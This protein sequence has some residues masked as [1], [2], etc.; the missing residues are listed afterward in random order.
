MNGKKCCNA[1]AVVTACIGSLILAA[2]LQAAAPPRPPELEAGSG[3]VELIVLLAAGSSASSPF[4]P[5]GLVAE[6]NGGH[7]SLPLPA[8]P[9]EARPL[10]HFR[11]SGPRLAQL[12]A[13]PDSPRARLERYVVLRF[14]PGTDVEAV[15]AALAADPRILHAEEN[16]VFHLSTTTPNDPLYQPFPSGCK[17]NNPPNCDPTKYQWGSYS[18]SLGSAWDRVK[19][20]AYVGLLDTGMQVAHPDLR[21]FHQD[22]TGAWIFDGGPYRPQFSYDFWYLSPDIDEA[23]V[24]AGLTPTNFGHGTHV[25]GILAATPNNSQ[26]VAGAC[27]YCS[28]MMARVSQI[29]AAAGG[30]LYND[31]PTLGSIAAGLTWLVDHGAQ[32]VS[33]S[34]GGPAPTCANAPA[35]QAVLCN[36]LAYADAHDVSFLAASGN[37]GSGQIDFPAADSRSIA[38]GGIMENGT[39]WT[40][41][42]SSQSCASAGLC[43]SNYGPGQTLVAPARIV[44]STFYQGHTYFPPFCGDTSGYGLCTG[45]SMASPYAAGVAALVRS[46]N[47]L[48]KKGDV[49]NILTTTASHP[50]SPDSQLGYGIPNAAAAVSAA[51]GIAGGRAIA[52]RLTPLFS[53]YSSTAT[54]SFYT[55]VPQMAASAVLDPET[56]YVSTGPAVP[57]YSGFPG[58]PG[59]TVSPCTSGPSA[60]VYIFTTDTAPYSG[61]PPLVP[62]YRL[63]YRGTFNGNVHHRDTTY[64]TSTVGVTS[65]KGVGYNFDGIEGYVYS[66]CTPEPQCI[67]NGAVRLYR[68]YNPNRDDW[69]IFP[70][71]ELAQKQADGYQHAACCNDVIGYVY[72]N[73][74]TDGDGLIDGFE[75][76]IGTNPRVADSDCDGISDGVEVLNYPYSDPLGPGCGGPPVAN[77]TFSCTGLT[78]SFDASSTSSAAGITAYSW[79]F[80]D[81]TS[82]SGVTTSHTYANYTNY[83]VNLTVTDKIL[84]QSSVQ[85]TVSVTSQLPDCSTY[86]T[87][88]RGCYVNECQVLGHPQSCGDWGICQFSCYC[89][90]DC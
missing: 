45:T 28:I 83:N 22:G 26:G 68:L 53:F 67:P 90:G 88:A 29:R 60:S 40:E 62:L 87:C 5:E 64:T 15:K 66:T 24:K 38:V 73:V 36:A 16:V 63:S 75:L 34:L 70:E 18:L 65:F 43:G 27:W 37:A 59:C 72:P 74:D 71:S 1:S 79:N 80:G 55:T 76:L 41:S 89:G 49:K 58:V 35:D 86:C 47:P 57:L 52:N 32:I 17:N 14:P 2:A 31:S 39:F 54:D 82:G 46:A 85:K 20:H 23:S 51:M 69:A 48:L 9:L 19:G 12:D 11:A 6:V 56:P 8:L 77:F 30:G 84:R 25:S 61:A 50:G 3:P 4:T 42:P 21:A 81:S 33:A 78:C 7:S 44:M 10:L 13:E